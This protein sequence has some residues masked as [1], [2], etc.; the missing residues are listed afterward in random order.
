MV[1]ADGW[2]GTWSPGI[3][4]PT[5][6]GWVIVGL[7]AVAV[8]LCYRVIRLE[9]DLREYLEPP[10]KWLW[11]ILVY[12]LALLG[13]NKQLDLQSALT[14]IAR[15]LAVYQGWYESRREMQVWFIGWVGL[16]ALSLG[17]VLAFVARRTLMATKIALIG[18]VFLLAFVFVRAASFH[19]FDALIRSSVGG[20]QI[21]WL[22]EIGGLVVIGIGAQLRAKL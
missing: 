14:E 11:W 16:A 19:H 7:Y 20:I 3:G 22:L 8:W 1:G 17:F 13:I 18:C 6:V 15:M 21:N 10:E 2:I 4:D 5:L 12:G 9:Y